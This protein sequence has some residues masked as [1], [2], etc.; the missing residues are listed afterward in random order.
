M[1]DHSRKHRHSGRADLLP[2]LAVVLL[3]ALMLGI[4]TLW[5]GG[6]PEPAGDQ[7]AKD[8]AAAIVAVDPETSDETRPRNDRKAKVVDGT[9]IEGVA[10]EAALKN[11]ARAAEAAV[12]KVNQESAT[13]KIASFNVLASQHTEPGGQRAGWP[14]AG[15]RS[16]ATVGLIRS[17]GADIVGMQ[18]VKS[19]QLSA[20]AGGTGFQSYSGGGEPD[21]AIIYNGSKFE[22]VSGDSFQVWFM[23]RNRP[24]TVVRLRHKES[25]REFYVIN[26]HTSAGHGGRYASSRN[27][28]FSTVVGYINRLKSEGV[29]IFLTGDMNDRG[30]FYCRVIPPTG[31]IAAQGGGGTCGSAPRMRPVDWVTGYGRVS[32]SGY[33]DD[34][35]SESRR[36]SDHPFVSATATLLGSKD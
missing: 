15:W 11:G 1:S 5:D 24:Q 21:N 33:V 10:E 7:S 16:G 27:A 3:G 19:G 17:H 34:F 30:N 22:F 32:F 29:P 18:E 6:L 26:M 12:K 36:I 25:R 8:P 20:I 28:A 9:L 2:V 4:A 35:S 13:F 31:L 23:S 14:G